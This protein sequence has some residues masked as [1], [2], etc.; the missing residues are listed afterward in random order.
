[1]QSSSRG[2]GVSSSSTTA[3]GPFTP[4]DLSSIPHMDEA[5]QPQLGERG[6]YIVGSPI[7]LGDIDNVDS[8]G[9]S[10][11]RRA[12]SVLRRKRAGGGGSAEHQH[13]ELQQTDLSP[14]HGEYIFFIFFIFLLLFERWKIISTGFKRNK[15]ESP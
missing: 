8:L 3:A 1:M 15:K 4:P 5:Q 11:A 14:N 13:I 2:G 6:P 10:A 9:F 7:D 12:S